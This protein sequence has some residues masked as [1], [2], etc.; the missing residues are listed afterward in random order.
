[1][2]K[3]HSWIYNG[4]DNR[5]NF[6]EECMDKTTT[7]LNLAFSRTKLV[8]CPCSRCQNT[9]CLSDK[10][11]NGRGVVYGRFCARF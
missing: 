3:D 4:W 11:K 7:F 6:S 8:R 10:V 9:K 2:A 1:M 5:G